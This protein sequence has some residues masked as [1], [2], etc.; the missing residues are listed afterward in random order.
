MSNKAHRPRSAWDN[1]EGLRARYL[2]AGALVRGEFKD[3]QPVADS[4]RTL[5]QQWVTF[6][7]SDANGAYGRW[8]FGVPEGAD[9]KTWTPRGAQDISSVGIREMPRSLDRGLAPGRE[10]A[11]HR[12]LPPQRNTFTDP[13]ER[14]AARRRS[15]DGRRDDTGP[16]HRERR[17]H[18]R[19]QPD[20]FAPYPRRDDRS[21][22]RRDRGP[23]EPWGYD[24]R[25]EQPPPGAWHDWGHPYGSAPMA[26]SAPPPLPAPTPAA[27]PVPEI[28]TVGLAGFDA[29]VTKE[30]VRMSALQTAAQ[31]VAP[32]VQAMNARITKLQEELDAANAAKALL[33]Q[34]LQELQQQQQQ[35]RAPAPAVAASTPAAV[36]E[37]QAMVATLTERCKALQAQLTT[38]Q[39]PTHEAASL[40]AQLSVAQQQLS[41]VQQELLR[42]QQE[43]AATESERLRLHTSFQGEVPLMRRTLAS[44][45]T[46]PFRHAQTQYATNFQ[47]MC[48]EP[49]ELGLEKLHTQLH[50]LVTTSQ[51]LLGKSAELAH[52]WLHLERDLLKEEFKAQLPE[53]PRAQVPGN[54]HNAFHVMPLTLAELRSMTKATEAEMAD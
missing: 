42:T 10:T 3:P 26:E 27:A 15:P 29:Y 38:M 11:L 52:N 20:R 1:D 28:T 34:Q 45:V 33:T 43:L 30:A 39:Q 4:H 24:R 25:W 6:T 32:D 36:R 19:R 12:R 50:E 41:T 54:R 16:G 44:L 2:V 17:G 8:Y 18:D 14:E 13:P 23:Y 49:N 7:V 51:Q 5:R 46:V 40:R 21:P 53:V 48:P 9:P 37:Q 35:Q 47:G 22:P 31:Q